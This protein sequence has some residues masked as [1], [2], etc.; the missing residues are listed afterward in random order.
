M[1]SAAGE[2]SL[3]PEDSAWDLPQDGGAHGSDS[4]A[5]GDGSQSEKVGGA[6][7][8]PAT[9]AAAEGVGIMPSQ[10]PPVHPP[11]MK[12][13]VLRVIPP[14]ALPSAAIS[15]SEGQ[16][17]SQYQVPNPAQFI[18]AQ[19]AAP[20]L[21]SQLPPPPQAAGAPTNAPQPYTPYLY[22]QQQQ[23][24]I[25]QQAYSFQPNS[26]QYVPQQY[27]P[28]QYINPHQPYDYSQPQPQYYLP[29]GAYGV[30]TLMPPPPAYGP[31]PPPG[32]V[33]PAPMQYAP[34]VPPA[35]YEGVQQYGQWQYG[36]DPQQ[37]Q[38]FAQQQAY[39]PFTT[40]L[41]QQQQQ[42][43]ATPVS[44]GSETQ[45]SILANAKESDSGASKL[46]PVAPPGFE[47]GGRKY[48]PPHLLAR[49][50]GANGKPPPHGLPAGASG[51]GQAGAAAS[52]TE[53][54]GI[55]SGVASS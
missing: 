3:G 39:P 43:R 16:Q 41:T 17:Q 38:Y 6:A 2:G 30:P 28:H 5:P 24:Y 12:P 7:V 29:P 51:E 47:Q 48:R 8:P 11:V 23:Q 40:P 1:T 49:A 14:S 52:A 46:L 42:Q 27:I 33:Y 53:G 15:R 20:L 26:M 25:P 50:S 36:P 55:D 10:R 37:L 32:T 31:P 44:N 22:A 13:Q 9:A 18:Q 35:Q 19:A 54:A 21:G 34:L 4:C 45:S